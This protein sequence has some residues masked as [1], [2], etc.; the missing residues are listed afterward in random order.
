M[1]NND[2]PPPQKKRSPLGP[3]VL[4]AL[5]AG[6]GFGAYLVLNPSLSTDNAMVDR[7]KAT[8]STKIMGIISKINTKEEALVDKGAVLVEL[9][10][11][12]LQAQKKQ[13][14][15]N[16][17]LIQESVQQVQVAL[18]RAQADFNRA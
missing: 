14:E 2:A 5:V 6:L 9:D 1:E 3:L 16:Q 8:V 17:E 11:A 15:V 4:L 18:D 13:A 7:T 10:A 12:E